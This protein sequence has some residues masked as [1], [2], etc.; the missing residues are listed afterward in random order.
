MSFWD[1]VEEWKKG[2][3]IIF[4]VG[5]GLVEGAMA[6]MILYGFLIVLPAEI[7][8]DATYLGKY[9]WDAS[10]VGSATYGVYVIGQM[11]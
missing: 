3:F 7:F 2:A 8:F 6:G 11:H 5:F 10:I 9:I 1:A 4:T